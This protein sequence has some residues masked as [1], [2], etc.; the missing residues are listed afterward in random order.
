[1]VRKLLALSAALVGALVVGLVPAGAIVNG[2]VPDGSG[3]RWSVSSSY[4]VPDAI[5]PRFTDP[6]A[7][8]T[9]SGT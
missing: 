3:I 5:D 1:M 7:Y 9:C 6:G 4:H 8:F 2:G